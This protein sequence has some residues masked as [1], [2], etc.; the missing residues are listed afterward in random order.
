MGKISDF[1]KWIVKKL[2]G[3]G[4]DVAD[5]AAWAAKKAKMARKA[6]A[7]VKRKAGEKAKKLRDSLPIP[8]PNEA[9]EIA[10]KREELLALTLTMVNGKLTGG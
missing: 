5:A 7:K 3:K 4:D 9:K 1:I 2:S 10:D 8:V 6:M